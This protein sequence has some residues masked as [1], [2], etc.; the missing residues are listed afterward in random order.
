MLSY[1]RPPT[2][3]HMQSSALESK[4]TSK[5]KRVDKRL[6]GLLCKTHELSCMTGK[7]MTINII[8]GKS[9]S[10]ES[11]S[12]C[13]E[14]HSRFDWSKHG[15]LGDEMKFFTKKTWNVDELCARDVFL[16]GTDKAGAN[17]GKSV[18]T[19]IY[20]VHDSAAIFRM[21]CG[22]GSAEELGK[23]LP[24]KRKINK[25]ELILDKSKKNRKFRVR[26]GNIFKKSLTLAV[27]FDRNVIVT[28]VDKEDATFSVA[29]FPLSKDKERKISDYYARLG[30]QRKIEFE[31]LMYAIRKIDVD[32]SYDLVFQGIQR[33]K[34]RP[35]LMEIE[36]FSSQ[37]QSVS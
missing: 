10:Y 13:G 22:S 15:I 31:Q 33:R 23:K 29:T 18:I 7:M 1:I 30:L 16:V 35:T 2:N 14:M 19:P 4:N 5:R 28:F 12:S 27:N 9:L 34:N 8:N 32:G 36:S 3:T 20:D 11:F 25:T 21:K 17:K 24:N 6:K 26:V 37:Y